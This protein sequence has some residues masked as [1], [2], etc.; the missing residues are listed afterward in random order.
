MGYR[1][2]GE[3]RGVP[4]AADLRRFWLREVTQDHEKEAEIRVIRVGFLPSMSAHVAQAPHLFNY[5]I[6]DV[7][8]RLLCKILH[9]YKQ[10]RNYARKTIHNS[11]ILSLCNRRY[12]LGN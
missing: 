10:C 12:I 3:I 4:W 2:G 6:K 5:A 9:Y 7:E 1:T 8:K 11:G